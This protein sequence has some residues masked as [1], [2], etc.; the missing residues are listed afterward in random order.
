[1]A[2]KKRRTKKR[3]P[4]LVALARLRAA[5]KSLVADYE[6]R[7]SGPP[8]TQW[9]Y[10]RSDAR[11][12]RLRGVVRRAQAKLDAIAMQRR[13]QARCGEPVCWQTLCGLIDR[14]QADHDKIMEC[15]GQFPRG[16]AWAGDAACAAFAV[17]V[18]ALKLELRGPRS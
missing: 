9:Q 7:A 4:G 18:A 16:R 14:L 10:Q 3:N 8:W 13:F 5:Q 6:Y 2:A 15:C 12:E 11:I 17:T 1:M